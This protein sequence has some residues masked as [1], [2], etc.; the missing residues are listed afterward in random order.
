MSHKYHRYNSKS[1]IGGNEAHCSH[2]LG[3]GGTNELAFLVLLTEEE[4]L[5]V[6]DGATLRDGGHGHQLVELFVVAHGQLD[7]LGLDGLLLVLF[8]GVAG[9]LENLDGDVLEHGSSEDTGTD[10]HAV[11]VLARSDQAGAA[12]DREDQIST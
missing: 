6:G 8:A 1:F 11:S 7:V 2:L 4:G 10:A 3:S 12:A 9:E 5:D